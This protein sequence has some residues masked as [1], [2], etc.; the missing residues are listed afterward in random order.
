MCVAT[1]DSSANSMHCDIDRLSADHH[2]L[3][4]IFAYIEIYKQNI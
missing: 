3:S 1:S 2:Q 4:D